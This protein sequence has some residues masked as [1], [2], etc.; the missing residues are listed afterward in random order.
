MCI[1]GSCSLT[2]PELLSVPGGHSYRTDQSTQPA[3]VFLRCALLVAMLATAGCS[4]HQ[5]NT[6]ANAATNA[7]GAEAAVTPPTHAPGPAVAAPVADA[8]A[9]TGDVK[10]TLDS[11]S[12][13]LRKY[14][15]R[16]RSVPKDFE[17]F[18]ARSHLQAPPAPAGK[19][20]AIQNQAVVLVK[21]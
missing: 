19:K 21:R 7:A 5:A 9:D 2:G 18:A 20:Y 14:V 11:L 12:Q 10:A 1:M 13:E 4:K 15:V 17:E 8:V 16:T 3:A 6:D